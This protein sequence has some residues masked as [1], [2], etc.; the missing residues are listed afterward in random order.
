MSPDELQEKLQWMREKADFIDPFINR[1]DDLLT[2]KD[3][4]RLLN[5]EI[6]KTT[7]KRHQTS[8]G[9][10]TTYSYWQLK[11]AWWRR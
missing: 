2:P 5:P 8:Y 3:I 10:E 1:E 9:H 4:D 7:E 6:T 11:N